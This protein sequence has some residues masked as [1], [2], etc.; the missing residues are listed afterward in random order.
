M[1]AFG[2]TW[3]FGSP[4]CYLAAPNEEGIVATCIFASLGLIIVVL[5]VVT[6]G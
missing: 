3:L 4:L 5:G 6:N 2:L 1:I